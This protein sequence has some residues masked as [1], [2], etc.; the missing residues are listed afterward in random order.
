[1][2]HEDSHMMD[3]RD[4]PLAQRCHDMSVD[5]GAGGRFTSCKSRSSFQ[6]M[7]FVEEP[8]EDI[9]SLIS[10]AILR[11]A[12]DVLMYVTPEQYE[13]DVNA[14]IYYG[15][16]GLIDPTIPGEIKLYQTKG[17]GLRAA[18]G[19]TFA[20]AMLMFTLFMWVVDPQD[21]RAGGWAEKEW[22]RK[23]GHESWVPRMKRNWERM[24]G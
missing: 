20:R 18:V 15:S 13:D 24:V 21:K 19:L 1:M 17:W 10:W 8:A 23:Y 3:W 22:Y 6:L 7:G 9:S 11:P 5:I 14:W 4:S 2:S 12:H 16:V